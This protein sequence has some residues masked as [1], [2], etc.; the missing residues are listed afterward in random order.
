[1]QTQLKMCSFSKNHLDKYV[2]YVE[3]LCV[4][5]KRMHWKCDLVAK[6]IGFFSEKSFAQSYRWTSNR[7]LHILCHR[8]WIITKTTTSHLR[9]EQHLYWIF[10][11]L[12]Q[13]LSRWVLTLALHIARSPVTYTIH[14]WKYTWINK[15]FCFYGKKNI[16]KNRCNRLV[17]WCKWLQSTN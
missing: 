8:E 17:D 4:L 9:S 3:P 5:S 13:P 15:V 16:H 7:A 6:F 2:F 10:F 12:I 1:M 14:T 11:Y